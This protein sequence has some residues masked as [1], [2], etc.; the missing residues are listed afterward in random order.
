MLAQP[1]VDADAGS[2]WDAGLDR[3]YADLGDTGAATVRAHLGVAPDPS[4]LLVGP[5]TDGPTL[6]RLRDEGTAALVVPQG[7]LTPIDETL[8]GRDLDRPFDATVADGP[9]LPAVMDD[10]GLRAHLGETGDPRLDAHARA[11]RP[12]GPL[13]PVPGCPPR[14][15]RSGSRPPSRHRPRPRRRATPPTRA[16]ARA[17]ASSSR[18]CSRA[19]PTARPCGGPPSPTCS[20]G[21]RPPGW[22]AAT[23]AKG[24][25][26]TRTYLAVA[27]PS[28]GDYPAARRD[29]EAE[30]APYRDIAVDEIPMVD[31]LIRVSGAR[32]LTGEEQQAY[33]DS[34]VARVT[35]LATAVVLPPASRVTLT[36]RE[37]LIPVEL[38]ND[39]DRDVQVLVR[40]ESDKL[41]FPDGDER[42][43]T[44][45]PGPTRLEW[46][47]RTRATGAFPV[48]VSVRSPDGS[49]E[50]D[51]TRFTMRSTAVPGVGIA[52]SAIAAVFLAIW[53]ARHWHTARRAR[54][55]V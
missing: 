2:W 17:S 9:T 24:P 43:V 54:D 13:L 1:Y 28:L 30:L 29:A 20:T 23:T 21:P 41:E 51:S 34:A 53:W 45:P 12:H 11:G 35:D 44:L 31:E 49:I 10:A 15:G 4:T 14:G 55:L 50:L 46:L 47:V 18:P 26:L 37:G 3:E 6:T 38:R 39:L 22:G 36:A 16:E 48:E 33:L 42:I 52:L 32:R 40:L 27:P 7:L 19:S 25:T 8:F 5:T